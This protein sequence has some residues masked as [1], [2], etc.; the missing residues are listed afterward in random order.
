[1]A[2]VAVIGLV[3]LLCAGFTATAQTIDREP[4]TTPKLGGSAGTSGLGF[5]QANRWGVVQ[6]HV[7]NRTATDREVRIVFSFNDQPQRQFVR[8]VTIPPNA[9]R[10]VE[11]PA[12][13]SVSKQGLNVAE[14]E[15]IIVAPKE[16]IEWDRKPGIVR[17]YDGREITA[18][19]AEN[20]PADDEAI[21]A[22]T[23]VRD[24]LG[25]P[26]SMGYIN[27]ERTMRFDLGWDGLNTL[28]ITTDRPKFDAVQRAALRRWLN[29]GGT[30]V[31]FL[32]QVDNESMQ[33][34]LGA[35]WGVDVV[36]QVT[37]NSVSF[38]KVDASLPNPMGLGSTFKADV[39][40]EQPITMTRVI[41]D[42]FTTH[43]AVRGWPALM[44]RKMGRGR[45]VINTLGG[46][47]YTEEAGVQAADVFARVAMPEASMVQ[48]N[49]M[50]P[51]AALNTP[52][53]TEFLA[54]Q[55]G[56]SIVSRKTVATVLGAFAVAFVICGL[57]LLLRSRLEWIGPIGAALA[58]GATGVLLFIGL[59]QRGQ[60]EPVVTS[61]QLIEAEPESPSATVR[62]VLGMFT[63]DAE[64]VDLGSQQGG[65]AW[66]SQT[67]DVGPLR[68]M[69]WRDL[70]TWTWTNVPLPPAA[71]RPIDYEAAVRFDTPV[72]MDLR[73]G[74]EGLT[75]TM[76]WPTG[77]KPRDMV[78]A[79]AHANIAVN[80]TADTD[81]INL[82][83]TPADVL[84]DGSYFNTNMMSDD[85]KN[86]AVLYDRM[87]KHE[88]PK[89]DTGTM[90][91][92]AKTEPRVRLL[93]PTLLTWTEMAPSGISIDPQLHPV[94]QALWSLPLRV[95]ASAPGTHV[96]IPW[97]LVAMEP[98]RTTQDDR[99]RLGLVMLPIYSQAHD[100]FFGV[101]GASAFIGRFELPR[102]VLPLNPKGA[103]LHFDV[104]ATN[105]SVDLFTLKDNAL[106]P[107]K[108]INSPDGP[109]TIDI[110]A[111]ALQVDDRGGV[112]VGFYVHNPMNFN[113]GDVQ[114]SSLWIVRRFGLE[115]AGEVMPATAA[116]STDP[117][118]IS[119]R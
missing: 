79:A 59:K 44:S 31:V 54:N 32:D 62:G 68:R 99:E 53:G 5:F 10:T 106:R 70:D 60:I 75:G 74:P 11:L 18:I 64:N 4:E 92:S 84:P 109:T 26:K 67:S 63:P 100:A 41:A 82:R 3:V 20:T 108:T 9:R 93:G 112:L 14:T 37:L 49:T 116:A 12:R 102:Q 77:Y 8:V 55:V 119:Q 6:A 115:V 98:A 34:L 52:A 107:I 78:I 80:T 45:I 89:Q 97:P 28:A 73:Y 23:A 19:V 21:F 27:D 83:V 104:T 25:L 16:D 118:T 96:R 95:N 13:F 48:M 103:T 33:L 50:E 87:L 17:L 1:M 86:H 38:N 24:R 105:R 94:G 22:V 71:L 57:A 35:A 56:Y 51:S 69:V 39:E 47:A 113:P 88:T 110:P 111:D 42:G 114:V 85:R 72:R 40:V 81:A 91:G 46:R 29:G 90:P 58:V 15:T 61:V 36:D 65:W 117:N 43:L 30:L 66:P 2:K 76:H 101:S 7:H